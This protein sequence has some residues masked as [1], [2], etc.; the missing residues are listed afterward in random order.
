M[1]IDFKDKKIDWG[2][3][4]YKCR[5]EK[6]ITQENLVRGICSISYLSKLE[7][8]NLSNFN[9]E[10]VSLLLKRLDINMNSFR[11]DFQQIAEDFNKWYS[12]IIEQNHKKAIQY[13]ED[14]SLN[15]EKHLD[16]DILIYFNLI[17]IRYFLFINEFELAKLSIAE[18]KRYEGRFNKHQEIYY[19]HFRGLYKCTHKYYKEGLYDLKKSEEM[20]IH[21]QKN[22]ELLYHL[23]LTYN[24]MSNTPL[25]MY[26]VTKALNEYN[27]LANFQKCIDCQIIKGINLIRLKEF[28]K[29]IKLYTNLLY[30][31]DNI[32]NNYQKAELLHNFGFVYSKIQKEEEAINCYIKSIELKNEN[33]PA[34]LE[35]IYYLIIELIKCQKC[36]QAKSWLTRGIKVSHKYN[37]EEYNIK[38]KLLEFDVTQKETDVDY[39]VNIAIPYFLLKSDN[40]YLSYLYEILS[41]H[42][43]K[44]HHYKKAVKYFR[45]LDNIRKSYLY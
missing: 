2:K 6:N 31:F 10:T 15:I 29:A 39:V 19:L 1:K 20:W 25:S 28:K 11:F 33:D 44:I 7:N 4:I 24:R 37:N 23:A 21:P 34:Y 32:H 43:T 14:I 35:S 45:L 5:Q 36:K 3:L 26:Y 40:C 8:G 18:L 17:S 16:V 12:S 9:E 41:N 27:K 42:Y 22:P 38:F 30:Q 13:F